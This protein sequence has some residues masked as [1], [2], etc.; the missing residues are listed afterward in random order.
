M[1][2]ISVG[3]MTESWNVNKKLS[4]AEQTE[5]PLGDP[6][7]EAPEQ[8]QEQQP[9]EDPMDDKALITKIKGM[10]QQYKQTKDSTMLR[11]IMEEMAKL[12]APEAKEIVAKAENDPVKTT[13]GNYGKYMQVLSG[14]E[15]IHR[16]AMVF[17]LR[18]AGAGRGLDDALRVIKGE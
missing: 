6:R 1:K 11:P 3:F 4:E 8:P 18:D 2:V 10:I 5:M 17:A 9:S 16:G 14:L 7:K 12:Y 15:G 13:R